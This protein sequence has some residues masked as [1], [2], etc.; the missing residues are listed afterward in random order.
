MENKRGGLAV[1][2]ACHRKTVQPE[3]ATLLPKTGPGRP[4]HTPICV[5][6]GGHRPGPRPLILPNPRDAAVVS[7]T[8]GEPARQHQPLP[9]SGNQR[10]FFLQGQNGLDESDL[11]SKLGSHMVV[12]SPHGLCEPETA[13][14]LWDSDW[15]A[16]VPLGLGRV[17]AGDCFLLAERDT[18]G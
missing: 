14:S 17:P 3:C 8:H 5:G 1:E 10:L 18:W 11:V 16:F 12:S 9:L 15:E 4:P 13:D 6:F 2:S 7:P